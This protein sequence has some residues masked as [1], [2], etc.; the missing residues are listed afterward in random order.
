M[1]I[2]P[3]P[4]PERP[5]GH[6]FT[7]V[8]FLPGLR[9][10]ACSY[11]A[12]LQLLA[13]RVSG[14]KGKRGSGLHLASWLLHSEMSLAF[15]FLFLHPCGP[16]ESNSESPPSPQRTPSTPLPKP[17]CSASGLVGR[18]MGTLCPLESL[19][20]SRQHGPYVGHQDHP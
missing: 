19:C 18:E 7:P 20:F 6:V 17:D 16:L 8:L 12:S 9:H 4:H 2:L 10:P 5:Q 3:C 14:H 13:G 11:R 1:G 15:G